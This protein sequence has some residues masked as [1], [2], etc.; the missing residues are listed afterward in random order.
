MIFYM[1][2]INNTVIYNQSEHKKNVSKFKKNRLPKKTFRFL[3]LTY[4]FWIW[5]DRSFWKSTELHVA[6]D[7]FGQP[8][9]KDPEVLFNEE[10]PTEDLCPDGLMNCSRD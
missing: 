10:K 8:F 7:K 5:I 1:N 9:C 2:A 4:W 6:F 3:K